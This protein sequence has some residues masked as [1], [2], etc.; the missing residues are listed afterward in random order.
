MQGRPE[1]VRSELG[2][3]T[4]DKRGIWQFWGWRHLSPGGPASAP[5][6]GSVGTSAA[7]SPPASFT[8]PCCKLHSARAVEMEIL[9]VKAERPRTAPGRQ[10]GGEQAR[11]ALKREGCFPGTPEVAR[12]ERREAGSGPGMHAA[13]DG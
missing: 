1:M 5:G 11:P 8:S 6:E 7:N 13:Q 12:Q 2:E 10:E 3:Q 4:E 9:T